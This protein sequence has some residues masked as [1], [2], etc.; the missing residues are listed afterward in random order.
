MR[1]HTQPNRE[2][3]K[4]RVREAVGRLDP[5]EN[6]PGEGLDSYPG[7]PLEELEEALKGQDGKPFKPG[8]SK[9]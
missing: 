4:Q 3:A 5:T 1:R 2:R 6:E 7:D 8:K 9:F